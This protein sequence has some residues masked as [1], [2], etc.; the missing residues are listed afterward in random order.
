M[1]L[2]SINNV[3]LSVAYMN[4]E[5]ELVHAAAHSDDPADR[6]DQFTEAGA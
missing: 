6:Y 2:R 1:K 4:D 5:L 3:V